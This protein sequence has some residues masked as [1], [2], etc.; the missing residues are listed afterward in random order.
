MRIDKVIFSCSEEY[1]IFWNIN[2]RIYKEFLGIQPI[3]LLFGKK[4]NTEMDDSFGEIIEMNF[5]NDL[6]KILQITWSKFFHTST[7][8]ETTWL[9]GDIDQIPLQKNWFIDNISLVPD[10]FHIHLNASGICQMLGKPYNEWEINGGNLLGGSDI[11]AHYHVAKGKTFKKSLCLGESLRDDVAKIIDSK[12]YGLGWHS[13]QWTH[14]PEL[15][16]WCAEENF[17]SEILFYNFKKHKVDYKG[18]HFCNS[19]ERI[20]RSRMIGND[21]IFDESKLE[22]GG[23]IDMHCGKDFLTQ[24]NSMLNILKIAN[25]I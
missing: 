20:C 15:F 18:Y 23:Y 7:E 8:P 24:E 10:E 1:S 17:S 4:S 16:Y 13:A 3:C 5:D 9:I 14:N 12:R 22:L 2:S 11:P 21:Y 25:I 19:T 6:N